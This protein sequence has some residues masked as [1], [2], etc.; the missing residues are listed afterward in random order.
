MADNMTNKKTGEYEVKKEYIT[1]KDLFYI[2][3]FLTFALV[4]VFS[5]R[6]GGMSILVNQISLVGSVSSILLALIAIGYA[7][8]Q[9]NNS[10]W[11]NRQM[12]DTLSRVNEKVEELGDI[13]DELSNLK[14]TSNDSMSNMMEAISVLPTKL[15]FEGFAEILK[16]QGVIIP[17]E[18]QEDIKM[19][20]Q[21][22]LNDEMN[23]L[24]S[25]VMQLE[26]N[27]ETQ[28]AN[29]IGFQMLPNELVN[30]EKLRN[31]LAG[32]GI[33]ARS[34]D[35]SIV[36]RKFNRF[37]LVEAVKKPNNEGDNTVDYFKSGEFKVLV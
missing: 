12:L 35:I 37:G 33:K 23:R 34:Q 19:K 3:L 27:L 6:A 26:S 1:K 2:I 25:N 7:F 10:S 21:E 28:I 8:F 11:E 22:K 15:N 13:K 32:Q 24:K 9:A 18:V 16:E 31:H 30:R 36:L 5:W 29:Y 14:E 17:N 20:Y 4:L